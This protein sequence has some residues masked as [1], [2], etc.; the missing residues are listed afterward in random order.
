[1]MTSTTLSD[2]DRRPPLAHHPDLAK[3][4]WTIDAPPKLEH[5]LWPFLSNALGIKSTLI[6]RNINVNQICSRCCLGRNKGSSLI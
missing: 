2:T 1:M 6:S 4:I 3:K 5:F